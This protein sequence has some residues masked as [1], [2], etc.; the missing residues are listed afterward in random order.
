MFCVFQ[1][2]DMD[3]LTGHFHTLL[4]LRDKLFQKENQV[5]Q[6]Y[7]QRKALLKREDDHNLFCMQKN[8]ELFQLQTELEKAHSQSLILVPDIILHQR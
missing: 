6:M 2:E 5:E 7:Q 3:D 4:H 8:N 1:F